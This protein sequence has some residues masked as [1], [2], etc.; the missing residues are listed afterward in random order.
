MPTRTFNFVTAGTARVAGASYPPSGSVF[1][2]SIVGGPERSFDSG[3]SQYRIK[4]ALAK[5]SVSGIEPGAHTFVYR[6]KLTVG[7]KNNADTR[8]LRI[9]NYGDANPFWSGI[10]A[11]DYEEAEL[12]GDLAAV[13]LADLVVGVNTIVLS[14][15]PDIF[16]GNVILRMGVSGG[17]PAGLNDIS[18]TAIS[19]EV[20]YSFSVTP[21]GLNIDGDTA[22]GISIPRAVS[23][24][25]G[26][27]TGE[28]ST[29]F[30]LAYRRE[31]DSWPGTVI[32][33]TTS[34][35]FWIAAGGTFTAGA[36][37][38]W[39]WRVR[40]YNAGA[41]VSAWSNEKTF[42]AVATLAAVTVNPS[43]TISTALPQIVATGM[44]TH[45]R[46]QFFVLE[47]DVVIYQTAL[48]IQTSGLHTLVPGN[49][50]NGQTSLQ[51]GHSYTLRVKIVDADGAIGEGE[52][53]VTVVFT[54]PTVPIVI[55]VD[56]GDHLNVNYNNPAGGATVD[57][58]DIRVSEDYDPLTEEGTWT[59]LVSGLLRSA[60]AASPNH[61]FY[62]AQSGRLYW[63]VARAWSGQAFVDSEPVNGTLQLGAWLF[64]HD[65]DDPAGSIIRLEGYCTRA[66]TESS[67]ARSWQPNKTI[68][69]F[70]NSAEPSSD[71][72]VTTTGVQI[73]TETISVS[74]MVVEQADADEEGFR[75]FLEA[76]LRTSKRLCLRGNERPLGL[77]KF[78]QITRAGLP[79][80][81]NGY[82]NAYQ[83]TFEFTVTR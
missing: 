20:Q 16:N 28:A 37:N 72:E 6:L 64:I 42:L 15:L 24:T 75:D 62:E 48:L 13:N 53:E 63:F 32:D 8:Q 47:D 35:Q 19:L 41:E 77:L 31:S 66:G 17:S 45:T 52:S 40:S 7:S 68:R 70:L 78:G 81:T 59:T 44:A 51:N 1:T 83:T 3:L 57:S 33:Q 79:A 9:D 74:V 12:T 67:F 5:A 58:V 2:Q 34:S 38:N 26:W 55:V 60:L 10:S 43:G 14:G 39:R 61:K 25:F 50:L 71:N 30:E 27:A 23:H 76:A 18:I 4:V 54:P 36:D 56:D 65:P 11:A 21:A 82:L 80:R 29:R 69:T 73:G 46:E 49:F 22:N